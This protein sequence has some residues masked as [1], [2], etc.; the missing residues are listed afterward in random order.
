MKGRR[1]AGPVGGLLL[2]VVACTG[3]APASAPPTSSA[4]TSAVT[5]VAVEPRPGGPGIG[6]PLFPHLGNGGYDASE[7]R[8]HLEVDPATGSVVG[9]AE[10]AAVALFDL[11][12]FDLD[13]VGLTVGT[14]GLVVGGRD[15]GVT[16]TREGRELKLEPATPIPAGA[17]FVT[18]VTYQGV[19]GPVPSGPV[20][21]SPGWRRVGDTI[22]VFDEPDGAA[23]WFPVN[24]HPRD[25]ARVTLE[26]TVP[27]GFVVVSAGEGTAE[28]G[29]GGD[30]TYR[31]V[32]DEPVAP[33]LIP[34]GI[35][36]FES[37]TETPAGSLPITTW[38]DPDIPEAMLEPFTRQA[39]IIGF[40]SER[41]G[42]YPFDR[43]G[44]LV[45]EDS[46]L[47]AA[48]ETQE[49]V[50]YTSSAL[51]W[52]DVV[53]AHE[54]AHQWFG[55]AVTV[56]R[57]DDIWLNEGFATFAQWLWVEHR[58]GRDVYDGEVDRAYRLVSGLDQ[59]GRADVSPDEA[60]RRAQ[61]AFPPPDDPRPDDLFN[62]SVYQRGGLALVALRDM[63]GDDLTF[64]ILSEWVRR[65]EGRSA[66]SDDFLDLVADLAGPDA[67][68]LVE[69][70]VRA[71]RIPPLP[72]RSLA[73]PG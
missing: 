12:S 56:D 3:P 39:E 60:A 17:T 55:D 37:R 64:E 9:T 51:V 28:D 57:W 41:F 66:T 71:P 8:L 70:F 11:S 34:L 30:T 40:F 13:F 58:R 15:T 35:G 62:A 44:A 14:V 20:P 27:A 31:W 32:I 63:V 21:F 59:A 25:R 61:E 67:A 68:A 47:R 54:L 5:T 7:Y 38:Y 43:A 4:S 69:S 1:L 26:V 22:Y 42:P 52:G 24:D 49:I 45:V 36:P 29:P 2:L 72:D 23:G 19:P 53:V 73:P 48:L 50:T 33:Y 65:Y 6:D 18:T 16:W 46:T 10:V